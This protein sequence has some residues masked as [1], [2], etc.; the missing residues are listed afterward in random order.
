MI[1]KLKLIKIQA[2][3]VLLRKAILH[4]D[5]TYAKV[6]LIKV[7]AVKVLL[8]QAVLQQALA[9]TK[10]KLMKVEAVQCKV[11]KAEAYAPPETKLKLKDLPVSC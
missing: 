4:Q 6:K 1:A 11:C 7:K 3:K 9:S 10:L 8:C 5:L 2:D